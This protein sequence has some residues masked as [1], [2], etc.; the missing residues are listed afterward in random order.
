MFVFMVVRLWRQILMYEHNPAHPHCLVPHVTAATDET[1]VLFS[2]LEFGAHRRADGRIRVWRW[3]CWTSG[4]TSSRGLSVGQADDLGSK[5]F[6]EKW[7]VEGKKTWTCNTVIETD[8]LW[9]FW[10]NHVDACRFIVWNYSVT[11][12]Q[13]RDYSVLPFS[14]WS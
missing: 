13:C 1:K 4:L 9:S 5:I 6:R 14:S 11:V 8:P 3:R 2:S 10:M 7:R 12:C